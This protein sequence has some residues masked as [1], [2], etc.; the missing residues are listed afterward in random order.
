MIGL[1]I[2]GKPPENRPEY[3]LCYCKSFTRAKAETMYYISADNRDFFL[4]L[5]Q[6]LDKTDR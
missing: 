6:E 5:Y 2:H 1:T 4:H 3:Y